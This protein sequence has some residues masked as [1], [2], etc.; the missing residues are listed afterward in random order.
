MTSSLAFSHSE[1]SDALSNVSQYLLTVA[2][3]QICHIESLLI[4]ERYTKVLFR[5]AIFHCL[6]VAFGSLRRVTEN[7]SEHG[8][9]NRP[10]WKQVSAK[11]IINMGV[12]SGPVNGAL[13][14][15][16]ANSS[17]SIGTIDFLCRLAQTEFD[18]CRLD[19]FS[20]MKLFLAFRSER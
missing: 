5:R 10:Y 9:Q 18:H 13:L 19:P 17:K 1:T 15:C 4:P 14:T 7:T 6:H 3:L 20:Y 16:W 12:R 8:L 2:Y 11:E